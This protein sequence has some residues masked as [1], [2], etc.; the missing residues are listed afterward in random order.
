MITATPSSVFERLTALADPTRSRLVALLERHELTVSEL[1]SILQL[2]Q[3]TVSRHLKVLVDDGWVTSRA[4]GTS[5]LYRIEGRLDDG[6]ARLWAIVREELGRTPAVAQ[7]AR[8]LEGVIAQRRTRSRAFFSSAAGSW[9]AL[10]ADLFGRSADQ[11]FLGLLDDRWVVGDLGCGTGWLTALI[12]PFVR[13]VVAMDGSPE[14]LEAATKRLEGTVNIDIRAG[15]LEKLP[16]EDE[17]L[18]LAVVALVLPYVAVPATA[19]AE[20]YRALKPD[21]R[22]LIVDM[23]SHQREEYRQQMGHLWLGFS[24]EE[25]EGWARAAGFRRPRYRPLPVAPDAK[26]PALFV[27]S[28]IRKS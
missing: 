19:L 1:C 14:M 17:T 10:R 5:R 6:A 4:E 8:R 20:A 24:R 15:D 28:A 21:G 9:D 26:G 16:L 22:I 12:A 2:P 13:R 11:A 27:A 23:M 18:D 25:V 3:S 7:D